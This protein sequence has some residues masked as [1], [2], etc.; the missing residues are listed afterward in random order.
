MHRDNQK[1]S[2]VKRLILF[3][4]LVLGIAS[5]V[6]ALTLTEN[7]NWRETRIQVCWEKLNAAHKQERK[8]VRKAIKQSWEAESALKFVG[9]RACRP[10]S[11]GIR[12]LTETSYPRTIARGR[13]VDGLTQGMVLPELWGLAALSV[14]L[15]APVHE[16]GHALGF[17]HEHARPD[18]PD[19]QRCGM[20][21]TDG[22]RYVERDDALTP[23]DPD[24]IMVAC[25]ATA[26]TRMSTGVPR[27]S[28]SD[29]FGLV[30]TYGSHPDN[31]LDQDE[32]G[33]RF[34]AALALADLDGD[35]QLDLAVGAP[36]EDEG[37]GAV[38]IFRGD[39]RRGFRPM[40]R[41]DPAD[42]RALQSTRTL[43]EFGTQV[44]WISASADGFGR[45]RIDGI[46]SQ[47]GFLYRPGIK[48]PP[49]PDRISTARIA[50]AL[51]ADRRVPRH[52][53]LRRFNFPLGANAD[54]ATILTADLNRDGIEDLVVGAPHSDG[55]A[56]GSAMIS[57]WS[58]PPL[59]YAEVYIHWRRCSVVMCWT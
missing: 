37:I 9:W 57:T 36:G 20:T 17:G 8:L 32:T 28:A 1:V 54:Q 2:A 44:T 46:E 21:N 3:A 30:Q 41:L 43:G 27:L 15:K 29:I 38:Y 51:Q 6:A 55:A 7:S 48:K 45:L 33:D 42:F 34:G 58:R 12:I 19:P 50:R 4:S 35:G 47:N 11:D 5:P 14:N 53:D 39:R 10:D 18:A 31:V 52:A 24:S 23:F 22:S 56:P 13:F 25:V 49:E 59:K 40:K 16:F 26:T